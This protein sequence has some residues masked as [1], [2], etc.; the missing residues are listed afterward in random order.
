MEGV[1]PELAARDHIKYIIPLI[2]K[3]LERECYFN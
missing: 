1:V 2:D 3:L